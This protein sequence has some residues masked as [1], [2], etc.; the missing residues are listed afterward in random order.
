MKRKTW[1]ENTKKR[2]FYL[3]LMRLSLAVIALGFF[4]LHSNISNLT[5]SRGTIEPFKIDNFKRVFDKGNPVKS[6]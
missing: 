3:T 1:Q 6:L 5:Q 2:K 4:P